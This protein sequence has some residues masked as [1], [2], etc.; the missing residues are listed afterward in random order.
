MHMLVIMIL[1][2]SFSKKLLFVEVD[3][4][5]CIFSNKSFGVGGVWMMAFFFFFLDFF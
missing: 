4:C 3:C 2:L 5:F 1:M